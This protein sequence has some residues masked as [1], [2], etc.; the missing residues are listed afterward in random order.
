MQLGPGASRL[1]FFFASWTRETLNLRAQLEALSRYQRTASGA[2]MPAVVGVDEASVEPSPNPLRGLLSSLPTP[3]SFP[4]AIDQSGR[5]ADGYEVQ[6]QPWFALV[7]RTGRFLWYYDVSTAGTI[8]STELARKVRAALAWARTTQTSSPTA[9]AT[10]PALAGSPAPLAGIHAQASRLLGSINAL[11]GRLRALRGYPVV[12][13]VWGSW[14]DPCQAEFP[15]FASASLAFGRRVAFLGLDVNDNPSDAA[16]FLAKHPVS[17]PSYQGPS[18]AVTPI[19]P[20][21]L[22]GT[23][24]TVYFSAAGK[25]VDVHTGQYASQGSLNGDIQQYALGG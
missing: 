10:N 4:V 9:A 17:Y 1:L 21:G 5:V 3:P 16:D 20:Q 25:V 8:S 22:L 7:S 2:H 12:L 24:T 14:C 11:K 6:D 23:P 13:N 19:L 15:L 18:D